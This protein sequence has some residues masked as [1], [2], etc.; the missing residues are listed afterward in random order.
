MV[1]D[2]LSRIETNS[3]LS[4]QPTVVD[5]AAMAKAQAV[6]PQI[7]ALQSSPSS[8]LVGEAIPLANSTDPLLCDISTGGQRPLIPLHWR[9]TV[10]DSLHYPH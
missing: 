3:L 5:F 8:S 4:G 7:R 10:F 6:D 2:A 9:H 1:A